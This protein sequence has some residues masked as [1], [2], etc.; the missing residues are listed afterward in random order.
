MERTTASVPGRRKSERDEANHTK[1][2]I[3]QKTNQILT[4]MG[5]TLID[6]TADSLTVSWAEIEGAIRYVLQYRKN[7][8]SD[9]EEFH[10]LSEKLSSTQ[11]R[12]KN[13]VDENGTGFF[14]RVGAVL[15]GQEDVFSWKIHQEPFKLLSSDEESS[16][17]EAPTTTLAGTNEAIIVSWKPPEK[18]TTYELQ[19]RENIGGAQWKSIASSL[20]GTEVRKKNLSSKNGYQFRVRPTSN[21]GSAPFSAPSDP[22]VALGLSDGIKRLFQSLE[23]STLLRKANDPISLADALGGKEFILLYASASWCGPCKQYSPMLS[24]WYQSLG[25]NKTVEVVFLSAD[26]DESG[27]QG[28][29]S[30]M[31]WL[32]V[33]YEEDTREELM[34]YIKTRGI[35]QLAVL[36]GRTGRII[37]ENA[38]GKQLDVNRWRVL[39]RAK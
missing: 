17:M 10:T 3:R 30:H 35:P 19:M 26:H 22:A 28:Y 25:S 21:D 32:A 16:R 2:K 33:D 27:F 18:K 36:D 31:P 38:V 15:K 34:G 11:A 13:L 14:F 5:I 8:S 24:K 1:H 20:S 29:Y 39:A 23:K 12:K 37:E 4:S 9:S 7:T 6:A